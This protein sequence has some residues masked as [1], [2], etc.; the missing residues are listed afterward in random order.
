MN[1]TFRIDQEKPT[2]ALAELVLSVTTRFA[3]ALMNDETVTEQLYMI[4]EPV[5]HR[6]ETEFIM[7]EHWPAGETVATVSRAR[8]GAD[9]RCHMAGAWLIPMRPAEPED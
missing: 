3:F 8:Y 4:Q 7:V 1:Y 9:A 2:T 5:G 6:T